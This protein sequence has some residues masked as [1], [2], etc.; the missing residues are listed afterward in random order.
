MARLN[1]GVVFKD[2]S[3]AAVPFLQAVTPYLNG[4]NN[5]FLN[6]VRLVPPILCNRSNHF[7]VER[8]LSGLHI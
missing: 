8:K 3:A 7:V 4:M 6:M 5:S 1:S 2:L